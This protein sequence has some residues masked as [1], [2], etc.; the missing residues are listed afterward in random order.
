MDMILVSSNLNEMHL[1]SFTD[2]YTDI[3]ERMPHFFRKD[4]SSILCWA[5]NMIEK[6]SLVVPLKNMFTHSP[7][8]L[9]KGIAMS[10]KGVRAAELRGIF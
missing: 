9:Q 8:L 5:H 10:K 7:I 2:P 1:I 4:L 3:F 6:E